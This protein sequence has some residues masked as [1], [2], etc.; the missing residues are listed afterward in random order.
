VA[1]IDQLLGE[2][3]VTGDDCC[4]PQ[5]V[6]L[7][8]DPPQRRGGPGET[9]RSLIATAADGWLRAGRSSVTS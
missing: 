3:A 9:G 5:F 4:A 1:D 7:V 2:R 8:L 6:E